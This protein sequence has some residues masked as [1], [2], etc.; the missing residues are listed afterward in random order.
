[1]GALAYY[2]AFPFLYLISILPFPLLYILS[3]ILFFLIFYIIRYRRTVVFTNLR[4]SFP[5]KSDV[6]LN[7]ISKKYYRYLSDL[8]LETFKTLTISPTELKK[9]VVFEDTSIFKKYYDAKQSIIVV[10][11]HWGNWELVGAGFS[12]LP[13]HTLYTIYHPLANSHFDRLIYKMRMRLGNKLY[14]M[15]DALRGMLKDREK[16]TAVAFLADQTP[17]PLGAYWTTFLNQDTPVFT[18]TEKIAKK[19]NYPVIYASFN[20]I[21][22]GYYNVELKEI[23]ANP[24]ETKENEIS[25]LHIRCLEKDIIR[26]PE[27]WLWT[28]RRWKHKRP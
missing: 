22:R 2:L 1:M 5:E 20:R 21:N 17:S 25:E 18:G 24:N 8:I 15:N 26:K 13:L 6:E 7:K 14:T 11:G 3:D 12:Q 9:R 16:V 19:L 28:H 27:I 10:L 4:N 23:S